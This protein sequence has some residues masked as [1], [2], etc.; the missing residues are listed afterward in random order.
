MSETEA[1]AR[2][3]GSVRERLSYCS[4]TRGKSIRTPA[5]TWPLRERRFAGRGGPS[6]VSGK[7]ELLKKKTLYWRVRKSEGSTDTNSSLGLEVGRGEGAP[8]FY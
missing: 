5:L 3:G 1:V 2:A 7:G 4:W 8:C 6:H